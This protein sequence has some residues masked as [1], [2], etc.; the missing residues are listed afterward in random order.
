MDNSGKMNNKII[1]LVKKFVLFKKIYD[2]KKKYN[3]KKFKIKKKTKKIKFY[4]T[5]DIEKEKYKLK[6]EILITFYKKELIFKKIKITT[7]FRFKNKKNI[8]LIVQS[9]LY[10]IL[11]FSY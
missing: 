9:F 6:I 3:K 2:K 8:I 4:Q 1:I 11:F 7:L 10:F 5:K